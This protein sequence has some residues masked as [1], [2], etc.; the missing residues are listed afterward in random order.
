MI[1]YLTKINI[2]EQVHKS[3]LLTNLHTNKIFPTLRHDV[4][5]LL[6][7]ELFFLILAHSVNKI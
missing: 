6:V 5:N 2:T 1:L 7:P 3:Q 4:I